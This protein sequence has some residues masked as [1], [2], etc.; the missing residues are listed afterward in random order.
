VAVAETIVVAGSLSQRAGYGGHAWVFLQYL[1]GFRRLGYDVLFVDRL[2]PEMC[3]DGHGRRTSLDA[4][5]N[6]SYLLDVMTQ[7]GLS[8]SCSLLYDRRS[9]TV[10]LNRRE[11]L[12]RLGHSV[13]LLNVMG[14]L[15]DEELLA[16]APL[17]AFLDID[18][19]FPQMWHALG[20]SQL[21]AHDRY[22]TVGE[23]VGR[24]DCSIPTGGLSWLT[25][26]PP[27]VLEHWPAQQAAG[28]AFTSVN[29]WRGPFG[30]IEYE[31]VTY[32]LRVHEM[33][34]FVDL[35]R[36]TGRAFELALDIDLVDVGDRSAL[37]ANGWSLVDPRGVAGDPLAYRSYV[38]R[39]A[40]EL[41]VAKNMYVRSRS[42]WFSDRS[43]CYLSSGRP[44]VAQDTGLDR[45]YPVGEGLVTFSTPEEAG[46]AVEDVAAH[47]ARHSAAAREVARASFD[48]DVVLGRLLAELGVA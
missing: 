41:M 42:G 18:P 38:Q 39:S 28:H 7:F 48:S 16:A 9:R 22:V 14:F 37:L 10:G 3:V 32:G 44:V 24:S 45:L 33:R 1:L 43:A 40:A 17:T 36:R 34:R 13:L 5:R 47:Y 19:G 27:V 26:R 20:L 23:N 12:E 29:S 21:P 25:T 11:L 8:D 15:N 46:A 2:D 31:G 6:L 4:S 30:P 35:P